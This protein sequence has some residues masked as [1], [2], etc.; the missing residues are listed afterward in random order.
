MIY[1]PQIDPVLLS[2]GVFELRWYGLMYLAAAAAF[3][4]LGRRRARQEWRG[5]SADMVDDMVF[6][7]ILG[8]IAGGRLAYVVFYADWELIAHDPW[9]PFK[10][11][12]GG[13]SF[14]GGVVGVIV[15]LWWTASR[16]GVPVLRLVDFAAALTPI[17][18]AF[19]RVGNFING[20]LW[21]RVSDAPWAMVFV[22]AGAAPRHPSQLYQAALEG[23]ALFVL[24][25]LFSMR[26]RRL[27]EVSAWFAIGYSAARFTVEFFR[28]PDAHI[29]FVAW[30][31]MTMGH[32]LTLPLAAAGVALLVWSRG[33]HVKTV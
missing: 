12:H 1:A 3:W 21:G 25:Y 6:F 26:S 17:G 28:E 4:G 5:V 19:G 11:W 27:G 22:H 2:I 31:W 16:Y 20:E 10:L 33:R 7:G 14:H 29:G 8:A 18:L 15:A 23:L 24:L 9:L 32:V 13:M 30:G